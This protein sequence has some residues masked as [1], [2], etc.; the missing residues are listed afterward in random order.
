M[1]TKR[2]ISFRKILQAFV[3][4]VLVG[5]CIAAILSASKV[6]EKGTLNSITVHLTNENKY[7]FVD[8]AEVEKNIRQ[9]FSLMNHK[10]TLN[11]I[12]LK[13]I[14]QHL[15]NNP[16]IQKAQTYLDNQR[17][18]HVYITQY[19]PAARV[20][21]DNGA[22]YY[23]TRSLKLLPLSSRFTYYSNVV[24]NVPWSNNDSV[25]TTI[26][27]QAVALMHIIERDTFWNTQIEQVSM[28][29]DLTFELYPV[30]GTHKILFGD[31]T[32]AKIKLENLLGFY[33]NI[34]NNIGWSHYQTLDLRYKNQIVASPELAWKKPTNGFNSN[35]DW[36]KTIMGDDPGPTNQ[37]T[38]ISTTTNAN[39]TSQ[40]V[41][42][43]TPITQEP[44]KKEPSLK[45][46]IKKEVKPVE[47]QHLKKE[48][49][50]KPKE[51]TPS[52][53]EQTATPKYILN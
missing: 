37:S 38:P 5:G 8:K 12:N 15:Y 26:R 10:T 24:T 16:W 45:T 23:I 30:L 9:Q 48:T 44:N 36:V 47:K 52:K 1:S 50:K 34:L 31:T 51:T 13:G 40:P 7:L 18:M 53:T 43:K 41:A 21:F 27:A 22:S 3:T 25:N 35:M 32:D 6:Q 14:E 20:F 33:K 17:N 19:T 39:S 46:T 28:T 29:P 2:N 4:L 11:H 49:P 42:A